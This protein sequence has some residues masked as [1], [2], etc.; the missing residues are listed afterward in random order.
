M[1][2]DVSGA[3][4]GVTV[5]SENAA[6]LNT[7]AMPPPN[8]PALSPSLSSGFAPR[9]FCGFAAAYAFQSVTQPPLIS[10]SKT[11]SKY[12]ATAGLSISAPKPRLPVLPIPAASA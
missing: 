11:S 9:S 5:T 6:G 4:T 10:V 3:I 2:Y 8:T 12:S 1:R 7:V